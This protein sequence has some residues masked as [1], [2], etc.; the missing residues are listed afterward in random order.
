MVHLEPPMPPEV[1]SAQK[2]SSFWKQFTWD[3]VVVA[4]VVHAVAKPINIAAGEAF[5]NLQNGRQWIGWAYG[6]PLAIIGT[7]FHWWKQW[8]PRSVPLWIAANGGWLLLITFLAI[9]GAI[10]HYIL[11]PQSL[12][13]IANAPIVASAVVNQQISQLS[14]RVT[15]LIKIP[16]IDAKLKEFDE[17]AAEYER[18]YE[19]PPP[20]AALDAWWRPQ[21]SPSFERIESITKE[22]LG[23]RVINASG[24]IELDFIEAN[25]G[26]PPA[27]SIAKIRKAIVDERVKYE[28]IVRS[29]EQK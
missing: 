22:V 2:P 4:V 25:I 23:K 16:W 21:P 9:S 26:D 29:A 27:E 28:A 1:A 5:V 3:D 8:L 15:A 18:T 20:G 7:T 19:Q 17:A 13:G 10:G 12:P 24:G 6:I 11:Q 14:E